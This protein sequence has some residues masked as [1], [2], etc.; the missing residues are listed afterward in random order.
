MAFHSAKPQLLFM[1]SWLQNQYHLCDSYTL[2]SMA[3]AW[4]TTLAIWNTASLC[5]QKTLSRRFHLSDACLFLISTNFLAPANQHQLSQWSLLFWTLK[6]ESCGQRCQVLLLSGAGTWPPCSIYYIITIFLFSNSFTAY[7]WL[8]WN[9]LCRLTLN[10]DICMVC[11]FNAGIKVVYSYA[12]HK[13]F[14]VTM[15]QYPN[16]RLMLSHVNLTHNHI[17]LCPNESNSQVVIV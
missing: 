17:S 9:L 10:S 15:L 4:G 2:P 5:S 6:P 1:T 7:A 3:T 13:L 8:P 12:G 16:Q 11:L 14:M